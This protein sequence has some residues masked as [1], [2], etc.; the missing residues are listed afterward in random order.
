MDKS[1][2]KKVISFIIILFPA[3]LGLYFYFFY[4]N[5]PTIEPVKKIDKPEISKILPKATDGDI[6]KIIKEIEKAEKKEP[7]YEYYTETDMEADMVAKKYAKQEEKKKVVK[8]TEKLFTIDNKNV[9]QNKYYS[10]D[11]EKKHDIKVG[12]AYVYDTPYGTLSYRNRDVEY[13]L[14]Y[15]GRNKMGAAI[16]YKLLEW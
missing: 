3:F 11:T 13:T 9:Y 8:T 16:S 12:I 2:F 15:G 14:M 6:K 10:I 7:T 4:S 1:F 5:L